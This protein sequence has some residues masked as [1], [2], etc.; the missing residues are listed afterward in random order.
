MLAE[1]PETLFFTKNDPQDRRLGDIAKA[2]KLDEYFLENFVLLGYPDDQGIQLNGGRTGAALAPNKIREYLYKMTPSAFIEKPINLADLGNL[3]I[4]KDLTTTHAKAL[5]VISTLYEKQKTPIS[6][7]GGHD[8]AYCDIAPF[9]KQF[10]GQRPLVINFDAHLDVR[11]S[12][13]GFNS[14]T[15]FFRL[16]NEFNSGFELVEAGIQGHCNSQHHLQWAKNR[17]AHII[18][19]E[20]IHQQGLVA[21]LKSILQMK[22]PCFLSIDIDGFTSSEAPGC[23]QSWAGGIEFK[24]FKKLLHEIHQNQMIKGLGIYEVSPALDIDH[25]TSKLAAQIIHEFLHL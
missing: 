25:R 3:K 18:S 13:N 1:I 23:S 9:I 2:R 14:G 6:L 24:D 4:E 5:Q 16:L 7:G 20:Q 17:G 19:M 11:D 22:R 10:S 15:P 12:K 8:Y 21:A